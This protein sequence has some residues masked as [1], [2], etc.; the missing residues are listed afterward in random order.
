M[1]PLFRAV[2]KQIS[3]TRLGYPIECIC[4]PVYKACVGMDLLL[5]ALKNL[6]DDVT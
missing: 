1:V 3:V 6:L 4:Y 2:V 5:H